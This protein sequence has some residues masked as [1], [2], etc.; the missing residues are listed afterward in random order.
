MGVHLVSINSNY[1]DSSIRSLKGAE[2]VRERVNVMFGSN[3]IEGAFH[4]VKEIIG[5]SL[6]E[7]RAGFGS[8]VT[9]HYYND[10][11]ISVRD[12]GR[13]VPLGWNE[14][15][16]RWNWDLVFNELYAGG[17]YDDNSTNYKFSIGLNGL[18]GASVQYTSEYFDVTS[19]NGGTKSSMHFEKGNPVG[20]LKVEP[21]TDNEV[22]TYIK[23]KIDN[24]VFPNTDFK[25]STFKDYCET[26][27]YLNNIT[28][29]YIN[30]NTNENIVYKGG[31]IESL[32]KSKLGDKVI[33]IYREVNS[34]KG[35]NAQNKSY[36]AECEIILAI[37]EENTRSTRMFFHNTSTMRDLSGMHQRAFTD[38]VNA[39]FKSIAENRGIRIQESDYREYISCIVSSYSSITSF[40]N[41]TK[42]AVSDYFT[43]E[44]IYNGVKKIFDVAFAKGNSS[45]TTL[46][47]NVVVAAQA[48]IRAKQIEQ[49][50]RKA[51]K[52]TNS[53][54]KAEKF[55]DCAE[56][57]PYM[58][59]LY[60]VEGDSALGACKLARD[61][62]FQALIPVQGKILN[63]LKAS[64]E[65]ILENKIISDL[66]ST[67][68]TGIDLGESNLFDI[69][70]LQF[71]KIIICTDADVD[72]F[73]IRV[74]LYTMFYRLMPELLRT[75]HVYI[76]ETPL[77]ELE[78]SKGSIFAYTVEE[79]D[80]LLKSLP[81]QGISVKHINRS[82]G[83]GENTPA[84]MRQTTMMPETRRLIQL[85]IDIKDEIVR[86]LST[87]L[88]GN[89]YGNNRKE[90]IKE[91]MGVQLSELIDEIET[92]TPDD[93]NM[94]DISEDY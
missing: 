89:D 63:C 51:K 49:A 93:R 53:R 74:L 87:I 66:T 39:F 56:K 59:E 57:N 19:Y 33:E 73:Q 9:V 42:D 27:A 28:I 65:K 29:Y 91:L 3:N 4:T 10:G 44:M 15:E 92:L 23:W 78:T 70:N 71:D 12:F 21:N 83:L 17:K 5:N 7:C 61:S 38:A 16:N 30:D 45:L 6:D 8:E 52:A 36:T 55:K 85:N 77:F 60:I 35:I 46:V 50:E 84:M 43:Y 69:D 58:R 82:K 79:K 86:E 24:D 32:L 76:A 90:Y 25:S 81:S 40:Y 64:I 14:A 2:R 37:T 68:G 80:S 72:G 18:G 75:G 48:R 54:K 67:V 41:Q 47:D 94:E 34:T 62:K 88:F 11:S 26:Q 13:G 1:D 22:G 31:G 20:E